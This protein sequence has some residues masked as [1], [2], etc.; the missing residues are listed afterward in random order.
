LAVGTLSSSLLSSHSCEEPET[1][2]FILN[3]FQLTYMIQHLLIVYFSISKNRRIITVATSFHGNFL[4]I[5]L[6]ISVVENVWRSW[7]RV[8]K[9]FY[10]TQ[11]T[12]TITHNTNML[13]A[14]FPF[15][16]Y[17]ASGTLRILLVCSRN[18]LL[19]FFYTE[20]SIT[21]FWIIF[22]VYELMSFL[23]KEAIK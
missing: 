13:F 8:W 2:G 5:M 18:L 15:F 23:T 4:C 11:S 17:F 14:D 19:I 1:V 6:N 12:E 20:H 3:Y 10:I 22:H 16:K 9:R 21:E 7:L